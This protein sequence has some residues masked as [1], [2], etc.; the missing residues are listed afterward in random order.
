M[1]SPPFVIMHKKLETTEESSL[2]LNDIM[3]KMGVP[4][5]SELIKFYEDYMQGRYSSNQ[6]KL[7]PQP[8]ILLGHKLFVVQYTPDLLHATDGLNSPDSVNLIAMPIQ[9]NQMGSSTQFL[10]RIFDGC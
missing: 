7:P 2:K 8:I 10:I 3:F 1:Y 6:S 9:S 4:H 5:Q